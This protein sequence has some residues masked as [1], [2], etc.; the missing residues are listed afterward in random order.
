M[1]ETNVQVLEH[2]AS[3]GERLK[4]KDLN[5]L[6]AEKLAFK[7]NEKDSALVEKLKSDVFRG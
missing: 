1:P 6:I 7:V 4:E 3:A 2:L 5:L